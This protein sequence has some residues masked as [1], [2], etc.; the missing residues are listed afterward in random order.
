MLKKFIKGLVDNI[1]DTFVSFK[2]ELLKL[3]PFIPIF[4]TGSIIRIFFTLRANFP[5][6]DGGMFYKMTQ[7][8][9]DN[10]FRLPMFTSYNHS[11]IPFAY[12]PLGFYA[13]GITSRVFNISLIN[14]FRFLPL[15][16]TILT[17]PAFYIYAKELF[18]KKLAIISAFI[19]SVIPRSFM[20]LIMG[21][22]ITRS[23]GLLFSL[24][25]LYFAKKY[26]REHSKKYLFY[27]VIFAALTTS[28]HLEW[29]F[30]TCYSLLFIN[31]HI[32]K[33]TKLLKKIIPII[34]GTFL[35]TLPWWLTVLNRF[36]VGPYMNFLKAGSVY[37]DI[38]TYPHLL[39]LSF[40]DEPFLTIFGT[41]GL[42][43]L[44]LSTVINGFILIVWFLTPLLI[45][46]RSSP[47]LIVIPL[48]FS[49]AFAIYQLS[50]ITKTKELKRQQRSKKTQKLRLLVF[51]TITAYLAIYTITST[52]FLSELSNNSYFDSITNDEVEAMNW[53]KANTDPS[54][55][56]LLITDNLKWGMDTVSEWF[57]AISNRE[58]ITT[59]QGQEWISNNEFYYKVSLN[60][61]LKLCYTKGI[62]CIE[63]IMYEYTKFDYVFIY[64]CNDRIQLNDIANLIRN[65]LSRSEKHELVF[66]NK[67]TQIFKIL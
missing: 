22:G 15:I 57:P 40:T 54:S 27:T 17:I 49:A 45:A 13:A 30:F 66:E 46:P 41:L 56:F 55:K 31:I 32:A 9:M 47:N 7:E 4:I 50:L 24:L 11:N 60:N 51:K 33:G 36:G 43:G 21:G 53:V 39:T 19:F 37:K 2:N 64:R 38:K 18:P 61:N 52:I 63:K 25:T 20:W 28:S 23:F 42:L 48:T 16:I 34:I 26:F 5:L 14:V 44:M 12:P 3:N 10:S 35:L 62:G 6:N 8:L 29:F 67:D 58:S 1:C 59:P 65:E